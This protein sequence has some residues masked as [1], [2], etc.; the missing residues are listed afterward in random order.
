VEPGCFFPRPDIDSYLLHLV[1]KPAPFIFS[2]E[3]KALIR[4][5]FQQRRKQIGGLLR[6]RLSDHGTSWLAHLVSAGLSVQTRPEAIPTELWQA[7]QTN[8]RNGT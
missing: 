3:N 1:R 2:A 8:Q 6:G 7:L 4:S 5:C